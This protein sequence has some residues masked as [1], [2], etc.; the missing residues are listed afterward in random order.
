MTETWIAVLSQIPFVAVF[1]WYSLEVGKQARQAQDRFLE[2]LDKRD[3]AFERRT[4]KM[5]TAMDVNNRAVLDTLARMENSA[6]AHDVAT[7]DKLNDIA[8]QKES[9]RDL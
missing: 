3:D 9:K 2:A 1:V 5:V 7:R 6:C 8:K 4:E